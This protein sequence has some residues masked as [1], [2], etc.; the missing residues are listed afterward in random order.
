[1]PSMTIEQFRQVVLTRYESPAEGA[2]QADT[3]AHLDEFL[4]RHVAVL[5][6]TT[7]S[8]ESK[9]SPP[10]TDHQADIHES[11]KR[12]LADLVA[13]WQQSILSRPRVTIPPADLVFRNKVIGRYSTP[14][15]TAM[16]AEIAESL[17]EDLSASLANFWALM[18]EFHFLV[19][20]LARRR[21]PDL[22]SQAKE[23]LGEAVEMWKA[24]ILNR[25][26]S[27]AGAK[28]PA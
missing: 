25:P 26:R 5:W 16:T 15:A 12:D 27:H 4:R 20:G 28:G 1:M 2:Q 14:C 21:S 7:V 18:S 17:D 22:A 3:I 6:S 9:I 19:E 8:L 13:T 24:S 11:L 23:M 10:P